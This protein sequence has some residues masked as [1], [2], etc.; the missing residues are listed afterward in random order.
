[1]LD[2]L[3]H[4]HH[5]ARGACV[6]MV[7]EI[8][9]GEHQQEAC[10][11]TP[12]IP[13]YCPA[14]LPSPS[15]TS[16]IGQFQKRSFVR[17]L[18]A[19]RPDGGGLRGLSCAG[20][21]AGVAWAAFDPSGA[22]LA[23]APRRD[24][25]AGAG[26]PHCAAKESPCIPPPFC[27]ARLSPSGALSLA[28]AAT[29]LAVATV[30]ARRSAAQ[31]TPI[32]SPVAAEATAGTPV[33]SAAA[34]APLPMPS[35]LAADAS[36]AVPGVAEALVA[37]MQEH[38]VPG[39][40][41]GLLAGDREEHATFG[42]AS[43]SSLRPVTPETLFQIGSLTKT[44]TSTAIWHLIDEGA[45]ALDAPV[46]TYLPE[47]TLI[48]EDGR[49]RRSP[50]PTSWT[51]RPG[52]TAMRASTRAKMMAPSPATLPS[53]CRNCPRSSRSASSS[54]TTTRP[55]P[56]LGRLIEVATGTT[57]NAAME[58]LLLGP[59][60]LEDSLLDHDA[61]R[62]RPYAD[63]HVAMPINGTPA[64][65]VHHAALGSALGRSRRWYLV[66]HPRRAPLRPFPHRCRDGPG[67]GERGQPGEP[68]PDA[69]AG[70]AYTGNPNSDGPG[71][72]RAGRRRDAG[73]LPWRRYPR[74]TYRLRCHSRAALCPG[75]ADQWPGW[76]WPR[77]RGRA[78]CRPGPVPRASTPG[79]QD[80]PPFG[81]DRAVRGADGDLSP[82]ELAEYAGRYA[83]PG[84]VITFTAK[85]E[86]LEGSTEMLDQP[87]AWQ[88]ALRP[89]AAP[90]APVAFLAKDMGVSNGGRLPFVRDVE[91]RVQWVSV[92][93]AAGAAR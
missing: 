52:G 82:E 62:Q 18:D 60:G 63:G 91:G 11:D 7:V 80:W 44:Y 16:T 13:R 42:L 39:A 73:L 31:V 69:G 4:S 70:D 57:Y 79:R 27:S 88:P 83:D 28:A 26:V 33:A 84:M 46:R 45:L 29:A 1:M 66:D 37:A 17:L 25:A 9:G 86:G 49:G 38:Q 40:A 56:L 14:V 2:C 41:I 20:G 67:T 21:Q 93:P 23:P 90:P 74:S 55:L 75:G 19:G 51:T 78:Q 32:A 85:S 3:R 50:S 48:D 68:D 10:A 77:G 81:A 8:T 6:K 89:P 36:P 71:L 30:P 43:L 58:H 76:R 5:R 22:I 64:L 61:V 87:G 65:S 59:L 34:A 72:V 54:P 15:T 24:H 47:L 92:R 53:G 12:T 35:T